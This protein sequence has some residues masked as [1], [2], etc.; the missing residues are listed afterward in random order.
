MVVGL[1]SSEVLAD[2][3]DADEIAQAVAARKEGAALQR[4]IDMTL[5][6]KRGRKE[7]RIAI[8]HK[9]SD[10]T[11]RATRITFIAPSKRR[12]VTFLSHDYRTD[13]GA[14]ARWMYLPAA[15]K[16]RRIPVSQRGNSFLGT[17]FSYEDI[18]SELKFKLDDWQF[19]YGGETVHEGRV[20]H[21]LSGTPRD[22][23]TAKELG[24]GAFSALIDEESW[25]P[26]LINFV[27]PRQRNLKTIEVV[28]LDLI[29]GIWT[30]RNVVATNH[31]TGHVT[32]FAFRDIDYDTKFDASLFD[33]QA[34]G[35]GLGTAVQE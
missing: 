2:S 28:A 17:D 34:L 10:D 15:R 32:E 18:Q 12:D 21:R 9:Q 5:T 30:V 7:K 8:V 26:V 6:N 14:D 31:H 3:H 16:V 1:F 13:D 35:R 33:P 23:R 22:S 11:R 27:D 29:D 20:R 4:T 24:Y 25:M 19:E